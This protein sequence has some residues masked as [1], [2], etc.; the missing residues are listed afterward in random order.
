MK[1]YVLIESDHEYRDGGQDSVLGVYRDRSVAFA[2]VLKTVPDA[3][4]EKST[5]EAPGSNLFGSY[6]AFAL[7]EHDLV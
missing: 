7:E 5:W 1:V 4:P 2:E 3:D 6:H